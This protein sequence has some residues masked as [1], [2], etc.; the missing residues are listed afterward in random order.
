MRAEM[1]LGSYG[2]DH[3]KT[4]ALVAAKWW[5]ASREM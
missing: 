4:A 5:P 2:I 1:P 3:Y